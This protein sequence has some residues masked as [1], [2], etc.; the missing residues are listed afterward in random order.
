MFG[1]LVVSGRP[2]RRVT[3]SPI[4]LCLVS[5]DPMTALRHVSTPVATHGFSVLTSCSTL[6]TWSF[7]II[8][9]LLRRITLANSIWSVSLA[10]DDR[11]SATTTPLLDSAALARGRKT[12]SPSPLLLT[13]VAINTH[14]SV[15]FLSSSSPTSLPCRS[16]RKSVVSKSPMNVVQSTNDTQ[17]SSRATRDNPPAA[18]SSARRFRSEGD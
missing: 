6:S 7:A 8:S 15:I 2:S 3:A 4:R 16:L 9:V 14:R 5:K 11:L 1:R 17:Q 12:S 18:I 13:E 10:S